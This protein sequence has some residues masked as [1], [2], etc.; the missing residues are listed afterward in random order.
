MVVAEHIGCD[1]L[2]DGLGDGVGAFYQVFVVDGFI[3][4]FE[5]GFCSSGI[6]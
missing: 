4:V 2:F 3:E 1:G 6:V 5:V